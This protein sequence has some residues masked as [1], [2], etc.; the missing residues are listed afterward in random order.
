MD[1]HRQIN[2]NGKELLLAALRHEATPAAPWVPF[3]GVH[4]GKLKNYTASEVLQDPAKLL[5]SLLAANELY[6]PDGQPV[7]F[8]LQV[9]AE[10]LGCQLVWAP[11]A[12]PSVASHPLAPAGSLDFQPAHLPGPDEGR[13]PMILEVM[14]AMKRA[15]GHRTALYGLVCGPFTLASHLRGTEIFMDMFDH[16]E[17]LRALLAYTRAVAERVAGYYIEAGMDVIAVVD[18][19]VSQISPRHFR[20]FLLEPFQQLFSC[21]RGQGVFS[22]FFVCGDATKNMEVMCQSGPDCI[23]I[24]ENIDLLAASQVTGRYNITLAGNIPLTTRMLLGSQQDNMKF[25]VDLLE[26]VHV[27]GERSEDMAPAYH[28][29]IL[30]PG[31]DMPYDTPPE[32]VVG[33]LQAVRDPAGTRRMLA[34]Y[35]A[36]DFNL[37]VE[38]PDYAALARPLVEVFTLDSETCAACGYMLGAAQRAVGELAARGTPVDLVEYKFTRA[39]NV[40]RVVQL[41]IQKLPSLYINGQ[42]K[43]SS[44]IPSNRE[45]VDEIEKYCNLTPKL[46]N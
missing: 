45:L 14:R 16:P 43:H 36:H 27:H 8:D 17:A 25:V 23:S 31:C 40:A 28:N 4:A 41:G 30:S 26:A 42:L 7:V 13:L 44:I 18:P 37:P 38:L 39:E 21:L 12:P 9:E 11:K 3:A 22:S 35:Q 24:D 34:N 19:L 6:D 20:S 29:F 1:V 32:N 2:R 46:K 33:V 15:V 5:A 10:L